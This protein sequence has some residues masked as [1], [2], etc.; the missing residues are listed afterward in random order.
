VDERRLSIDDAK[1]VAALVD[2]C[3]H[4][5][6]GRADY[7]M[8]EIETDLRSPDL[9]HYGWYDEAGT[10]VAYGWLERVGESNKVTVDAYVHPDVDQ[11]MGV[12]LLGRL[13]RR[14]LELVDDAG[15]DHAVFDMG[16]YRE[17]VRSASWLRDRGYAVG[18]TYTRMR[19]DLDDSVDLSEVALGVSVRESDKSEADLRTAHELDETSFTEHY[20]HVPRTF[21]AYR[22][23][24][25]ESGPDWAR[26]WLAELDGKAVGVLV[27]TKQFE[28]DEDAGYVRTLGVVPAARGRGVAKSLLRTYFAVSKAGGRSAALLHVDVANKTNALALYESVGMRPVLEI[29]AWAKRAPVRTAGPPSAAG[30]G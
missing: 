19:I 6:L 7:T 16:I 10:L 27:G 11:S 13:E 28:E 8:T 9:E 23:W 29:D 30:T 20:G 15:H 12:D 17:D 5:V 21:E 3:D 26:L 14:G 2:A 24:L 4:A 1:E 18:T 25:N 22:T